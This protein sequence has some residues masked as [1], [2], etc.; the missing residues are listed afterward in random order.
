MRFLTR[1]KLHFQN[2]TISEMK[3]LPKAKHMDRVCNNL[4]AER[5]Y[6]VQCY[7][8][9]TQSYLPTATPRTCVV[10]LWLPLQNVFLENTPIIPFGI[11]FWNLKP[12]K[13]SS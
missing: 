11:T 12:A 2:V 9:S 5:Y 10:I 6:A 7:V 3:G 4:D 1:R 8:M 13:C